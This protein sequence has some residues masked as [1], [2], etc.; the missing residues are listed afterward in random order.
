MRTE[1]PSGGTS[2]MIE[3]TVVVLPIPLRPSREVNLAGADLEIDPVEDLAPP[4]G[5]GESLHFEQGVRPPEVIHRARSW[6][7]RSVARP[8]S[9]SVPVPVPGSVSGVR[10]ILPEVGAPHLGI[11]PDRFRPAG[12][13]HPPR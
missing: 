13:D 10:K 6:R 11:G 7:S 5:G 3:Y 8:A 12:S 1:P 4:V 9:G 2:P